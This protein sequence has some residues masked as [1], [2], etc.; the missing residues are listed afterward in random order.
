MTHFYFYFRSQQELYIIFYINKSSNLYRLIY[1]M[2]SQETLRQ[3]QYLIYVWKQLLDLIL[4]IFYT[5]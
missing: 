5:I 3:P 1:V 4:F 2:K